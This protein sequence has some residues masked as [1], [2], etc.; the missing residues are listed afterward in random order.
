ME[1]IINFINGTTRIYAEVTSPLG[2][3]F[4]DVDAE[5]RNYIEKIFTPI[6][7][8]QEL[9]RKFVLVEGNAD[10]LNE[11]LARENELKAVLENNQN[12]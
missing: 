2:Y 5:E 6:L 12:D 1:L 10:E 9:K 8:E 7:N 11:E 3:C 4:Y